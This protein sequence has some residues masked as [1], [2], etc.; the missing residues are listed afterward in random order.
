[1]SLCQQSCLMSVEMLNNLSMNV[2]S[3]PSWWWQ[4]ET[5]VAKCAALAVTPAAEG[6]EAR[7]YLVS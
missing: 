3:V 7:K 6:S 2:L 5:W 4:W 1:M